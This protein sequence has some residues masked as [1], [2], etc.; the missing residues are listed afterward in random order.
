MKLDDIAIIIIIQSIIDKRRKQ[1]DINPN[2]HILYQHTFLDSP[3]LRKV[4][5]PIVDNK[6]CE[7]MLKKTRLGSG[8][9][10]HESFL[11]AG[12]ELGRDTCNG[13]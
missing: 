4:E 2:M 10:L 1:F 5:L 6:K 12:G 11:C 8:F 13:T 7:D 3:V 9:T